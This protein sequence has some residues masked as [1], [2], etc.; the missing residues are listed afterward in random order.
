MNSMMKTLAIGVWVASCLGAAE[1]P[2]FK[3]DARME[4]PALSLLEGARQS[5][6]QVPEDDG[7]LLRKKA[8]ISPVPR[9]MVSRMPV[10]SPSADV[11]YKLRTVAPDEGVEH[12][13]VIKAPEIESSK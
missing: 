8:P 4:A 10:I 12:K 3:F 1:D 13:M 6:R 9:K 7:G 2:S 5:A 11:D